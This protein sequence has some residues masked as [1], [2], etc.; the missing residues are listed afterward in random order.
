MRTL[1][2]L[3]MTNADNAASV[4]VEGGL[5]ALCACVKQTATAAIQKEALMALSNI[6][7]TS[8]E[9]NREMAEEGRPFMQ[10]LAGGLLRAL[11]SSEPG[12]CCMCL[13]K[14]FYRGYCIVRPTQPFTVFI[15]IANPL[16]I[17]GQALATTL[18]HGAAVFQPVF[19][20]H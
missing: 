18:C 10:W 2:N 4:V 8:N 1:G 6:A 17:M 14:M 19:H 3:C 11:T 16:A 13:V 20:R 7:A 12:L 5:A 15:H 9:A